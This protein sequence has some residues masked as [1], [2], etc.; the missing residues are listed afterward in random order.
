MEKVKQIQ[1]YVIK[2]RTEAI[3]AL[4]VFFLH[5]GLDPNLF[6][7]IYSV[8]MVV[9]K[10]KSKKNELPV[11]ATLEQK[12]FTLLIDRDYV[13]SLM[14]MSN[15][16]ELSEDALV[17]NLALTIVHEMLHINRTIII[18][19]LPNAYNYQLNLQRD[20]RRSEQ[21]F[22]EYDVP[23][24][25]RL[26]ERMIREGH[27]D[28]FEYFMPVDIKVSATGLVTAVVYNKKTGN[29]QVYKNTGKDL[30]LIKLLDYDNYEELYTIVGKQVNMGTGK[31]RCVETLSSL[32]G[33]LR[34]AEKDDTTLSADFYFNLHDEK[35][36]KAVTPKDFEEILT[37]D[38]K[39]AIDR[40]EYGRRLEEAIT[41]AL[42][43]I[44][45]YSKNTLEFDLD[46]Y[47]DIVV[48]N[49]ERAENRIAANIIRLGG[50]ELLKWFATSS[51]DE[52]YEDKLKK[53][54]GAQYYKFM[55]LIHIIF[56]KRDQKECQKEIDAANLILNEIAEGEMQR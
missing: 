8:N 3:N 55:E 31:L 35:L 17:L 12:T 7:H 52:Y 36:E 5:L 44:I 25:D 53:L 50:I 19:N 37:N 10:I 4:R 18:N 9:R 56:N 22:S 46:Y 54:F 26:T 39:V 49:D 34:G 38:Y 41:E 29:F 23:K 47:C 21:K 13:E 51:Y 15:N 30:P 43:V 45:V 24:Y 33:D 11:C 14:E 1:D 32:K 42:A 27:L 40:M 2:A 16:K 48:G 20:I 28:D 6:N